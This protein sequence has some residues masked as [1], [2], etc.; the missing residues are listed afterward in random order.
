M[1]K[2]TMLRLQEHAAVIVTFHPD[3]VTITRQVS[4]LDDLAHVIFVDN[5]S[6]QEALKAL[7]GLAAG[8]DHVE[9]LE[10]GGNEGLAAALNAGIEC[11]AARG[12]RSVLLLDQ[13]SL[14][15]PSAPTRLL[16]GLNRVQQDTGRLCCAGPVLL[17]PETGMNHGFHYVANGWRWARA[18]PPSSAAPIAVANLNGSGTTMPIDLFRVLGPLDASLFIDH[19]DT[20]WS[21]RV[22]HGGFGLFGLPSVAFDHRMGERGRRIWLLGWRVWPE[23]SPLRHYFLFRN[24]VRLLGRQHVPSVWKVW[25]VGK[26]AV[27]VVVVGLT[28]ARRGSQLGMM[29]KGIREA[30]Q[31]RRA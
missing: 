15:E 21:F 10:L 28:D 18:F 4:L 8:N 30:V 14:F 13:D 12:A 26:M 31:E 24:T 17:D 25:A 1:P 9:V 11:A 2:P 19:V 7:R 29:W 27:S 22:L 20:D 23:R 3:I 5:G 16:D 6:G